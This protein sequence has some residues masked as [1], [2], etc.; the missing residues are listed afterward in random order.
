MNCKKGEKE[1][2]VRYLQSSKP[3]RNVYPTGINH[4]CN[5]SDAGR[6]NEGRTKP[7]ATDILPLL[8]ETAENHW[9]RTLLRQYEVLE[10]IQANGKISIGKTWSRPARR[11]LF[12]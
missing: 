3:V 11:L 8:R 5:L 9:N 4:V 2:G 6:R 7:K 10:R 12:I 1:D